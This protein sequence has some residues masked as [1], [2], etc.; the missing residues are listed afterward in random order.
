VAANNVREFICSNVALLL[1]EHRLKQGLSLNEVAQRAG[2]SRQTITFI[3]KEERK[4]TLDTLLRI[5]AVIGVEI[6][7]IIR[8]SRKAAS[9]GK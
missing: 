8:Q 2:L 4:P 1:R 9:N 3:E 5:T 7:D 6:E